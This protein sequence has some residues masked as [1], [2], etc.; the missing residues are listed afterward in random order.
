MKEALFQ[1]LLQSVSEMKAIRSG[2][3]KPSRTY[4]FDDSV[5]VAHLRGRLGVTQPIFARLVGISQ[6]TLQ[7]WEQGRRK[8]T[9][10]QA[11]SGNSQ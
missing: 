2:K 8:P 11:A 3:A 7:T 10:T 4:T 1:E 5:D 6:K 9:G